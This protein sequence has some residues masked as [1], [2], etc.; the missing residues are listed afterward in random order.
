M[1]ENATDITNVMA[2]FDGGVFA[3]QVSAALADAAL[4][5]VTNGDKGRKGKVTIE[6]TLERIGES[7]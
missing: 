1:S 5:V 3:N 4:G 7:S 2:D 6:L